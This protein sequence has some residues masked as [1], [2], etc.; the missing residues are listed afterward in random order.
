MSGGGGSKTEST[1]EPWAGVQPYLSQGYQAAQQDVLDK[2]FFPGQTYPGFSPESEA[3]LGGTAQRALQGS[4]LIDMAQGRNYGMMG[5]PGTEALTNTAMGAYTNRDNPY[6]DRVAESV[7]A[8]VLPG[9]QS[10]F[11]M[12]GRTGDSPLA[13]GI[14]AREMTNA[15][16]PYQFGQYGQERG[17]QEQAA[18]QLAS[19]QIAGMGMAPELAGVDFSDLARL[20]QVGAARENKSAQQ[21]QEDMARYESPVTRLQQYMQTLSGSAPLI[22][23]TSTQQGPNPIFGALGAGISAS[24]F[25]FM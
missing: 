12:A 17:F 1:S 7:R 9:V 6:M 15:L 8:R 4:P 13:Q 11:G 3:A 24:P 22:G 21:I 10:S 20:G 5:A 2:P 16:A 14:M 19:N 18:G 23:Q 25:F